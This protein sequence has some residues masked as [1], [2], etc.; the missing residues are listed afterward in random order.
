VNTAARLAGEAHGG[1][2]WMLRSTAEALEADI[3]T[4][5]LPPLML[6]GKEEPVEVSAWPADPANTADPDAHGIP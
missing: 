6:K 1:E 5:F 2:V 3:A 4:R